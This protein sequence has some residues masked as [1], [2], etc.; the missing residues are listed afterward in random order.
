MGVESVLQFFEMDVATSGVIIAVEYL[1]KMVLQCL[2]SLSFAESPVV[3]W[4]GIG[5]LCDSYD[6][7]LAEA[8]RL[9]EQIKSILL[10]SSSPT[11]MK[12]PIVKENASE[13]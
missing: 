7:R 9:V 8:R 1:D 12:S 13:T 6:F 4:P 10:S 11:S 3:L 5:F 2:L